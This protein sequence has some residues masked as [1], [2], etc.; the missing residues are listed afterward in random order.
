ML[1]DRVGRIRHIPAFAVHGR[2]DIVCSV[3]NLLDLSKEW[4]ELDY[5][6]APDSGHSSHEPGITREL[7]GATRRI[8][9]TGSPVR[10]K[11]V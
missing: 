7:I 9:E 1:L 10:L 5:A 11:D 6:V 4:P 8:V 2:Y 3:K